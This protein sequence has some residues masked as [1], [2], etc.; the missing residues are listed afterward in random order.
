MNE[1]QEKRKLHHFKKAPIWGFFGVQILQTAA[2]GNCMEDVLKYMYIFHAVSLY[3]KFLAII[4][5]LPLLKENTR[6]LKIN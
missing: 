2:E 4:H 6:L 5:T 1:V 3:S